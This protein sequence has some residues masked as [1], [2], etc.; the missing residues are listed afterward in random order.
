MTL[1]P[2][3]PAITPD[4][5]R[6]V[7]AVARHESFTTAAAEVHLSQPAVSRQ[8]AAV[9]NTLGVKL[10]DR[11]GKAAHL[12]DAG[13]ALL[14]EFRRIMGDIA[15][16]R[17]TVRSIE[18]G[19]H[20]HLRVGASA[21]PG[22]YLIPR[23]LERFQRRYPDVDVDYVVSNTRRVEEMVVENEVDVGF[24]GGTVSDPSLEVERLVTDEIVCFVSR[25]HRLARRRRISPPDL[26]RETLVMRE[27]GSA[28]GRSFKS[29]LLAGGGRIG[30]TIELG[31]PEAV[32][33]IVAAGLGVGCLSRFGLRDELSRRELVV[34]QVSGARLTRPLSTIRHG[35]KQP[36]PSV[37]N[38]LDVVATVT[39]E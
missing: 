8:V 33:T 23:A 6:T 39:K 31:C 36:S 38:F 18:S 2:D 30:R 25:R 4:R 1:P 16:L 35:S 20:G 22:L 26:V 15:R 13:R 17:D 9:E 10:F 24:V 37:G 19:G 34:L 27:E 7:L 3:D 11:L 14:P 29:W 12:T 28:T 21:T 5:L 32:K